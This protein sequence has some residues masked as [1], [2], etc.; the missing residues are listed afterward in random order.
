MENTI[1]LYEQSC[2]RVEREP[3]YVQ[4]NEKDDN[5]STKKSTIALKRE[6]V[7]I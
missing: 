5:N 6:Y 2:P 7:A 4:L 3:F 1:Q